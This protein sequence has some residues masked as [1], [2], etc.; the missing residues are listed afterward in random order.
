V[1]A[2][3]A[4]HL[5]FEPT[6]RFEGLIDHGVGDAIGAQLLAVLR[7][8]LSNV[9]RHA[10]ATEVTVTV[11]VTGDGLIATIIDDG[12]G[13]GPAERPGGR[14]LASLR[15]RDE[16]LGGT[17]AVGPGPDGNGT[18]IDWVVPLR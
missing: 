3:A 15:H 13:A 16:T 18:V 1:A 4:T 7:E 5:G 8:S 10:G 6:V 9:V 14:G 11:S 17:L 12:I 2:E